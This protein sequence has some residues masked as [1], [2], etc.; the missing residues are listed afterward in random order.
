MLWLESDEQLL[1]SE[2]KG[3]EEAGPQGDVGNDADNEAANQP[4]QDQ[5]ASPRGLRGDRLHFVLRCVGNAEMDSPLINLDALVHRI[6]AREL[7]KEAGVLVLANTY[8]WWWFPGMIEAWI[9]DNAGQPDAVVFYDSQDPFGLQT[10]TTHAS[11]EGY[12]DDDEEM[13]D[14]EESDI[15]IDDNLPDSADSRHPAERWCLRIRRIVVEL[16][17]AWLKVKDRS[18]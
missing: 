12:E 11:T 18:A 15:E 1:F 14:W 5:Q 7:E 16:S 8:A 9:R 10:N 6:E 2:E 17:T 13:P 3:D 4:A